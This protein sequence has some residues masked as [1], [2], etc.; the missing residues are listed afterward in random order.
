MNGSV[1][2]V[3]A[4][5][6]AGAAGL[7]PL[8]SLSLVLFNV[9]ISVVVMAAAG[10]LLSFAYDGDGPAISRKRMFFLAVTNTSLACAAVAVFPGAFGWE[11]ASS[12]IEG[13]M[14]L[15]F[16]LSARF[17]AQPFIR[18]IPELLSKW[19]RIGKY[20][21]GQRNDPENQESNK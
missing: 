3:G 18:F 2:K 20:Y 5:A 13:S 8:D 11:W 7:G 15:L 21:Q 16:A 19:L 9:P 4:A 17:V 12:K 6:V 10:S 1:M 14:A